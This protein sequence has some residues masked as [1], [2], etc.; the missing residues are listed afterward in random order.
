MI[1]DVQL[2]C[3]SI[4]AM[5]EPPSGINYALLRYYSRTKQVN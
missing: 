4:T 1:N 2:E 5:P 3:K